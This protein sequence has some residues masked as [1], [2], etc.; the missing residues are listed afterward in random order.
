MTDFSQKAAKH[1]AKRNTAILNRAYLIALAFHGVYFLLRVVLFR[2]SFTKSSLLLYALFSA[3]SFVIQA[4]F[5]LN[6]RPQYGPSGND[7]RR[8]GQD[9]EAPGLTEWMWD[10][11]YW[12]WGCLAV[13]ALLGDTAWWLWVSVRSIEMAR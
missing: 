6:S 7:I 8:S 4:F 2:T 12:T 9:L 1:T 11:L 3:P 5:E 10:V 13:T